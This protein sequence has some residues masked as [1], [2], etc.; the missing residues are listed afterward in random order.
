MEMVDNDFNIFDF[1][2]IL[3]LVGFV[4]YVIHSALFDE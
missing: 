3:S 4:Y 2:V 1:T